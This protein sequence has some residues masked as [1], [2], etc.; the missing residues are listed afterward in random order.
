M[1]GNGNVVVMGAGDTEDRAWT[2]ALEHGGTLEE[3]M[4]AGHRIVPIDAAD[5]VKIHNGDISCLAR[6]DTGGETP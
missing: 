6:P 4:D 5:Y 2:S 3:L 1:V